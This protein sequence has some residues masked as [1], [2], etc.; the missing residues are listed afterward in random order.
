MG[1][2]SDALIRGQEVGG[3]GRDSLAKLSQIIQVWCSNPEYYC[4]LARNNFN[5]LLKRRVSFR[6]IFPRLL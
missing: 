4:V 2:G 3:Q 1:E 6:T 5:A